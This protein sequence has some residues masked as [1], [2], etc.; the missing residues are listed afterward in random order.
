MTVNELIDAL[1][2]YDGNTE[3]TII[4]HQGN[5][6][7]WRPIE[8]KDFETIPC[9]NKRVMRLHANIAYEIHPDQ[10]PQPLTCG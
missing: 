9:G 1:Y 7:R 6:T 4:E 10:E 2:C 5:V 3:V 8:Q